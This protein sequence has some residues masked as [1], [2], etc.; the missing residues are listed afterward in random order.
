MTMPKKAK[1][2]TN[3]RLGF[4]KSIWASLKQK[5]PYFATFARQVEY[6]KLGRGA[7]LPRSESCEEA[8]FS[9][10]REKRFF[11]SYGAKRPSLE[12]ELLL[13]PY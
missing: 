7:D 13:N 3:N 9:Q 10:A 6:P 11:K 8:D 1:S 4:E 2:S 12:S 5:I